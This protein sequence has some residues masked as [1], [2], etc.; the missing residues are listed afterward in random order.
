MSP[1][2][3]S[4]HVAIIP[5]GNRR[6][7]KERHLPGFMGHQEGAKAMERILEHAITTS[8]THLTLWGCSIDNLNKRTPE[9]IGF[10]MKIFGSHFTRL[11]ENE[12]LIRD[13]VRVRIVG[14]WREFFPADLIVTLDNLM[15][16]T[17]SFTRRHLTF[18]MAYSGIEEMTAAVRTIAS[19]GAKALDITS[20]TIKKHLYTAD[21]PAVDLVIRTGGSPHLS[22]GFMM[23]DVS[24]AQLY[25]TDTWWPA[26]DTAEF[27]KACDIYHATERRKGK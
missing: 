26:F 21:L 17:A 24:D 16:K 3:Q 23:W 2:E 10:L 15:A 8:V 22:S 20:E 7:A 1:A 13:Q 6:W 18:L 25:F 11:L 27:D 4:F 14:R 5:D 12:T 19:Q 9:E